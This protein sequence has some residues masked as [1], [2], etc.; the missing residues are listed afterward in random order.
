[1]RL[2]HVATTTYTTQKRA[3][4]ISAVFE[5][6]ARCSVD[7]LTHRSF[8]VRTKGATVASLPVYRSALP[9]PLTGARLPS[10]G[11][12]LLSLASLH[13][14]RCSLYSPA[15]TLCSSTGATAF[16]LPPQHTACTAGSSHPS[17]HIRC[18]HRLLSLIAPLTVPAYPT[19]PPPPSHR[20]TLPVTATQRD[21][22]GECVFVFMFIC[23]ACEK[24]GS[25]C[26]HLLFCF[27]IFQ[28]TTHLLPPPPPLSHYRLTYQ[29]QK[30]TAS[31][32]N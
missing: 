9:L 2:S 24:Y 6:C 10:T 18:P 22:A 29:T 26:G 31:L 8:S 25:Q 19:L 13:C 32:G 3:K 21:P 17:P 20:R 11:R 14:T 5:F 27:P 30:V 4:S 23:R 12:R 15:A 28:L 7:P 1:M 16:F